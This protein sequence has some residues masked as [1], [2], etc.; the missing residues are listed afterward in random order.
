MT[1]VANSARVAHGLTAKF[2]N[3]GLISSIATIGG[4][5]TGFPADSKS[6]P[7]VDVSYS[8]KVT[9]AA[10]GNVAT[11]TLASGV[12]AQTTG[13]PVIT[14]GDGSDWEGITLPT[15]AK[16]MSIRLRAKDANTGNITLT[17]SSTFLPNLVLK[18]GMDLILSAKEAGEAFTS[19]TLAMTFAASGDSIVVDVLGADS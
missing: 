5:V 1:P 18:P 15:M 17:P 6:Y 3:A 13:S 14:E 10:T 7:L 8:F 2:R 19:Q 16:L 4:A 12:V 9:S 11:L